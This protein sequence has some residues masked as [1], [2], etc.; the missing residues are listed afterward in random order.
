M[1]QALILSCIAFGSFFFQQ[2]YLSASRNDAAAFFSRIVCPHSGMVQLVTS[3]G[4]YVHIA[5][6]AASRFTCMALTDCLMH[7]S[8]NPFR[9]KI[10]VY[11]KQN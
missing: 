9:R 3:T 2:D 10:F 5:D 4:L 8:Y 7:V 6:D 1:P 11:T